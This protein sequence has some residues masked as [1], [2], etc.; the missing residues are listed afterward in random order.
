M[1]H[2][3]ND[4]VQLHTKNVVHLYQLFGMSSSDP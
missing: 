4:L 2:I 1:A 3:P